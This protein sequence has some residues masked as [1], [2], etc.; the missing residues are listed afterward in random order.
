[1]RTDDAQLV[2]QT[3]AGEQAA[4]AELV[5]RYRDA[6][7]GVAYH[8]LGRFEDVQ[9]AAQEAFVQSYLH[10]GQLHEPAKFAPWLRR[11]AANICADILRRRDIPLGEVD[12]HILTSCTNQDIQNLGVHELVREM[13]SRL[14]EKTRLTV[15]LAYI[16]GYS[17]GEIADFLEVPVNTVRS[18]LQHAK[19][20]L[21][22]E[23][24][25]M[26]TDVLHE[27]TPDP[28][29][30]YRVVDEAM[31]RGKEASATHAKGAAIR[32]YDEALDALEKLDPSPEQKKRKIEALCIKGNAV[33]LSVGSAEAIKLHEEALAIAEKLGDRSE[34]AL[35]LE[36]I[37]YCY[38]PEKSVESLRK[39][40]A[41]YEE[42]DDARGQG[43]CLQWLGAAYLRANNISEAKSYL[44]RAFSLF[45]EVKNYAYQTVCRAGLDFMAEVGGE[46][47]PSIAVWRV[48]CTGLEKKD[49]SVTGMQNPGFEGGIGERYPGGIL[50]SLSL[51][52]VL[53]QASSTLKLLDLSIPVGGSW[54]GDVFAFSFQPLRAT[55]TV[56]SNSETVT[57]PAGTFGNCLLIEEITPESDLPDDARERIERA[58]QRLYYGVRR[59][60]YAPG[61]GLV[62]LHVKPA[63]GDE[64]LIQLK[65]F[66]V[67]DIGGEYLPFRI[68]N[69]WTYDWADTPDDWVAKGFYRVAANDGD[70]WYIENYGYMHKK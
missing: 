2:E 56:R 70:I 15:T 65:E 54:S 6:V 4:F 50:P 7:S 26:V 40:L 53:F 21:R 11:I 16:N 22:E 46:R 37:S 32:H 19:K 67:K 20:Q 52:N 29:F 63:E 31:R 39:A 68:G 14:S 49:V 34:L 59:A 58:H 42:L 5:N 69:S 28:E 57:V 3:L 9:D 41:I 24:M 18:R 13:L 60:W 30:T 27:G 64:V 12:E 47:F 66:S 17:H 1:M 44:E 25:N 33:R 36:D 10:L 23:M 45:T 8:Y 48:G 51:T 38:P 55:A 35:R 43:V 62:Q 61:V